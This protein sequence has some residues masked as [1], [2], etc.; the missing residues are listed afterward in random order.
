M[1]GYGVV[2]YKKGQ[3]AEGIFEE[4]K[5]NGY[6]YYEDPETTTFR[7]FWV[8]GVQNGFGIGYDI[9][10]S[11]FVGFWKDGL[12]D[13]YG[14]LINGLGDRYYGL[15]SKGKKH[16]YC[17]SIF[18]KGITYQGYMKQSA[19]SGYG[20]CHYK[21]GTRYEGFFD[22]DTQNGYGVLFEPNNIKF[23]GIWAE[24]SP[25]GYGIY[26]KHGLK[27]EGDWREGT[28]NGHTIVRYNDTI[29]YEGEFKNG[30]PVV[31]SA[32][33]GNHFLKGTPK[34]EKKVSGLDVIHFQGFDAD[35]WKAMCGEA[36]KSAE[37]TFEENKRKAGF[38][39]KIE[40]LLTQEQ[41]LKKKKQ[42]EEE[43]L[44]GL[45]ELLVQKQKV[46]AVSKPLKQQTSSSS[47]SFSSTQ[48]APA[49]PA[50][51]VGPQLVLTSEFRFHKRISRWNGASIEEIKQF[52][53]YVDDV[54]VKKYERMTNSEIEM[55]KMRHEIRSVERL[56]TKENRGFYYTE[57]ERGFCLMAKLIR[58]G[59]D[60]Y[61]E[62]GDVFLGIDPTTKVLYHKMFTPWQ[63]PDEW[64]R[65]FQMPEGLPAV[66]QGNDDDEWETV[67]D[68]P[69]KIP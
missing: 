43:R 59:H 39:G 64:E 54:P 9:K 40:A 36:I 49:D 30:L 3:T 68:C 63:N 47:S 31:L 58:C 21:G 38:I 32:M 28:T 55:W 23:E 26:E 67:G 69:R 37:T 10:G 45:R 13:G 33:R 19:M 57:T 65:L 12:Q 56:I 18:P 42:K 7:G 60:Y 61:T 8:N 1:S 15:W 2:K 22:K 50:A 17:L 16:G 6:G 29:V 51:I 25:K 46:K 24:G 35:A 52:V 20:I 53:D 11:T 27:V 62:C 66:G 41:L 44:A 34:K 14:E 48:S 5:L 4:G